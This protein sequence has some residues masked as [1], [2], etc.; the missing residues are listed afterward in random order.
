MEISH[1]SELD[2]R[3]LTQLLAGLPFYKEL[4]KSDERQFQQVVS[5]SRLVQLQPSEVIMRSGE[6]GS[7]LYYLIKGQLEVLVPEYEQPVSQI[8]PGELFG[9]L[10]LFSGQARSA[11]VQASA[12][13]PVVTVIATNYA[14]FGELNDFKKIN[15]ATK[16]KFYQSI[17]HSV[18]WKL[19]LMRMQD[20]NHP[21]AKELLA[22]P[23]YKGAKDSPLELEFLHQQ[24][25]SLSSL[26]L[27][28]RQAER[29][30]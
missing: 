17:N 26:L 30:S 9:D 5:I 15:L 21:F 16:L 19:E 12:Q 28:W 29:E 8:M 18:R 3:S 23:L 24:V 11:T 2:G 6:Q 25:V 1:L 10:A 13:S 14:E 22:Q 4:K 27:R 7:W 20:R